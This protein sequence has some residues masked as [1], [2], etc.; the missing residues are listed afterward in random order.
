M[1]DERLRDFPW[2]I[3]YGPND[4]RLESFYLPALSRSIRFDLATGVFNSAALAIA[5]AGIARLIQAG[6]RMRL[7]CGAQLSPDDVEAIKR[8][9]DLGTTVGARMVGCL[10]DPADQSLRARLEALAWM[11]ASGTLEIRVVLPRGPDGHPL[12][13]EQA[14]EYYHPKEGLFEDG[15]GDRLA[16]S[17]SSNESET[18]WQWNYEVF[19]V[20]RSWDASNPYLLGVAQRFEALWQ[21]REKG[22][23]ALSIPEAARARLLKYT[24]AHAPTVDPLEKSETQELPVAPVSVAVGQDERILFQFVRDAPFLPGAGRLGQATSTVRPWPHQQRVADRIVQEFPRGFLLCD[25]VGLGKTI[26]AGLAL[27]QLLLSGQARRVLILAPKSVNRQWQEELY[28]KFVLNI[29]RY[30]GGTFTD[31][32][33]RDLSTD[34]GNPWDRHPV[35]VASSQLAKRKDRQPELLAAQPWDLILVDEAHHARRKDFLQL[36]RDRPNRLL[37]LLR[38]LRAKTK[39]LLLLTAT[40][41]QIHPVEV[42]DLLLSWGFS[43]RWGAGGRTFLASFAGVGRPTSSV[44]DWPL[45]PLWVGADLNVP[46]GMDPGFAEESN[47][48]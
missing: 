18:G 19:A 35:L 36:E 48:G 1:V 46:G 29:P 21:G 37:E 23:I 3:S 32:F 8:G 34:G 24:P 14:R 41:M 16:F 10:A 44:V 9:A 33:D 28:E 27:R 11:V 2:Q 42:W 7:L 15:T 6:G 45:V 39:A 17:G 22:W 25:E 13:A 20:Y 4:D 38:Q 12:A 40:P 43:G 31:V 5:A 26:E 47:K 30:D